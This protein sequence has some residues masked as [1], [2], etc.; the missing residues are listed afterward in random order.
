MRRYTIYTT[1]NALRRC[2][3]MKKNIKNPKTLEEE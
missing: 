2:A 1:K 3:K